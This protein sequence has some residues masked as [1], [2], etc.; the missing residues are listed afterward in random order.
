MKILVLYSGAKDTAL[1][2]WIS[3]SKLIE[4]LYVAPGC[5]GTEAFAINLPDLDTQDSEQV[6]KACK[7]YSIDFVVIG[8]E[9]PLL[10]GVVD[11]LNSNGIPCFGA[12]LKSLNLETDRTYARDF[13]SRHG[14]KYPAYRVFENINNLKA[15]L[16]NEGSKKIFTI[17]PNGFAISRNVFNSSD[18]NEIISYSEQIL[19]KGP[20][21]L[22]DHVDGIPITVTLLVDM[23]GYILL[24]ICSEYT[25]REHG[26][27]NIVTGGMGAVSPVPLNEEEH[28]NL[29][30]SVINPIFEGLKQEGLLYKGVLTL[31]LVHK[32]NTDYLV[33]FH[34]RFNDPA[35]QTIIP[36]IKN[37][38]VDV[39]RAMQNNTLSSVVLDTCQL[40]AVS[41][42]VASEG[43]PQKP[44][45][46]LRFKSAAGAAPDNRL[47]KAPL[48]FMGAVGR[49]SK[50]ALVTTGGRTATVVAL[51][52][53][54]TEA[55]S[56]VY[57]AI[58]GISFKGSWYREDIGNKFFTSTVEN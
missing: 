24:P 46:G 7:D 31:A 36:L 16:D 44:K 38:A 14:V 1:A 57:K 21:F 22:E 49:D 37:D 55:N 42:V 10:A 11:C 48:V 56:L 33:D 51:G 29:I 27:A 15:F 40:S 13:A 47:E 28:F 20:V 6:L 34:L 30:N 39:F 45:K 58:K 35:A 41:V 9:G 54:I 2:W 8:T 53:N 18:K 5:P 25:K 32:D 50:G 26:E 17:K 52:T 4:N 23:N 19:K 3:K 43:Y 12:P